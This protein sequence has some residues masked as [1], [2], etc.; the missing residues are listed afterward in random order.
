MNKTTGTFNSQIK[1]LNELD[2]YIFFKYFSNVAKY[3]L[4]IMA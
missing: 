1:T 2:Y 4:L 3:S